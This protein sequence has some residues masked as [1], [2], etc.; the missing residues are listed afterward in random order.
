[1]EGELLLK[2]E[3]C[4]EDFINIMLRNG[5]ALTMELKENGKLK[6]LYFKNQEEK[7]GY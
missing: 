5:Y 4:C 1:M 6:I 3:P 2:Y 7:H